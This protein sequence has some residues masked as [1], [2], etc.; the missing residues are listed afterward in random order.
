MYIV[1]CVGCILSPPPSFHCSERS[2]LIEIPMIY[3]WDIPHKKC[4]H[5]RKVNDEGVPAMP[6]T[7]MILGSVSYSTAKQSGQVTEFLSVVSST[8]AAVFP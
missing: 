5:R 1:G 8:T 2:P 6:A 7:G 3:L 4:P